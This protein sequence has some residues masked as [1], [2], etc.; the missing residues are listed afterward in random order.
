MEGM[1]KR[2]E[3]VYN[4]GKRGMDA[5]FPRRLN[6][7][8]DI[9]FIYIERKI[10]CY[11]LNPVYFSSLVWVLYLFK[12]CKEQHRD[13]PNVLDSDKSTAHAC[14]YFVQFSS[15]CCL[16]QRCLRKPFIYNRYS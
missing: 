12:V 6:S 16:L 10:K 1:M 5:K 4:S 14:I 13:G 3:G 8:N 9:F 7:E 15:T 2:K 11:N